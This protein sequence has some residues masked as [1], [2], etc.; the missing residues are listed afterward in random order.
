MKDYGIMT[1]ISNRVSSLVLVLQKLAKEFPHDIWT[2][3]LYK[4]LYLT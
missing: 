4:N 3:A 2:R 1:A